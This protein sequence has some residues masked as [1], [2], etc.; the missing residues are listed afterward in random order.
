MTEVIG[1][2]HIYIT[3]RELARSEAF[4]DQVF[5]AILGFRKNQFTLGNVPHIQ[6][7]KP[8]YGLRVAPFTIANRP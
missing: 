7:Y 5:L 3:V 2:D 8:A 1:I 4:Y 6:Y